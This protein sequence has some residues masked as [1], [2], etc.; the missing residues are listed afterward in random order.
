MKKKRII[1]T[2]CCG[3][4]G[5]SLSKKLL[6]NKNIEV[7][8]IDTINDYYDVNLKKQRLKLLK[9][10]KNFLFKKIDI[11]N[12]NLLKKVFVNGKINIVYNLRIK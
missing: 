6:M 9:N 5:F 4:I 12:F 3:F 10:N 11:G 1:V 8:G 7:I 2:G